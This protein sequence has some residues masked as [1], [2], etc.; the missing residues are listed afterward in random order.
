[1]QYYWP[2]ENA[3]LNYFGF[4]NYYYFSIC[5]ICSDVF[6]F[7]FFKIYFYL[8]I[9]LFILAVQ[10]LSCSMWDLRCGMRDLSF[11]VAAHGLLSCSM[12]TSLVAALGL[13]VTACELFSCGCLRDLVPQRGIK[14]MLPALGA[15]SFTHCTTRK[16]QI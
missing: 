3:N 15:Q 10:G 12:Q 5:R 14:L 11:L 16:S 6:F 2:Q 7:F 8:F 4:F 13:L 9:Y 1:M